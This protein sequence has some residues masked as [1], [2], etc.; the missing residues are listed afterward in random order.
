MK[1][2]VCLPAVYSGV[3]AQDALKQA[4]ALGAGTVEIW[5]WWDQDLDALD[6]AKEETGLELVGM[7]AKMVPLN[8]PACHEAFVQG[9]KE[10]IETAKRF[11]CPNL[12]AQ[13]GN[14]N[15]A[16]R[17]AQHAAIVEGLKLCAPVLEEAGITLLVEPLNVLVDH[18]GYYLASS[19]EGA[20][21]IRAVNSPN[22]KLLF[23]IYHQQITEGNLIANLTKCIDTI[24]HVHIA[25]VPGRHEPFSDNEI[26]Y[27]AVLAAL[28]KL[29]YTGY[30]GLEYFPAENR[31]EGL[32]KA[33]A[34][35]I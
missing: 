21:I 23:D 1:F 12:I 14:D 27:P 3:S 22:V 13:V 6:R 30:V 8:D 7:C 25:G 28:G 18:I 15:G 16:S 4:A 34:M 19:Q 31:E 33:L 29:G 35:E 20:E 2:S 24:G 32:K 26:N 17:A 9:L 10:S 11:G 5:G